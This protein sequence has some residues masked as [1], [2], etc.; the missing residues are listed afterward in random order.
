MDVKRCVECGMPIHPQWCNF[1]LCHRCTHKWVV[2]T[3]WALDLFY[4]KTG[5][6]GDVTSIEDEQRDSCTRFIVGTTI[7]LGKED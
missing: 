4:G 1:E 2:D 5:L 7:D 3:A 6:G